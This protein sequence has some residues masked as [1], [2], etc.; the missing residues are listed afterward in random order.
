MAPK[1]ETAVFRSYYAEIITDV[2]LLGVVRT[3][4]PGGA[5]ERL[6]LIQLLLR[7]L[8]AV[9]VCPTEVGLSEVCLLQ[10]NKRQV[11]AGYG[12]AT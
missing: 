5:L 11:R 9:Q 12:G 1:I 8:S 2:L 7:D 4:W 10:V 6:S 3:V